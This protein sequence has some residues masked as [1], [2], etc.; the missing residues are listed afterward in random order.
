MIN[1]ENNNK[2]ILVLKGATIIPHTVTPL[3]LGRPSS[4]QSLESALEKKEGIGVFLQKN[5]DSEIIDINDIYPYGVYVKIID[6]AKNTKGNIKVLL[7][8]INRIQIKSI[9][10]ENNLLHAEYTPVETTF[11]LTEEIEWEVLWK[12][13]ISF[14]QKYK[15]YNKKLPEAFIPHS[16]SLPDI[17]IAIDIVAGIILLNW[18]DCLILRRRVYQ[19]DRLEP[20]VC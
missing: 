18:F 9:L 3:L 14:Y 16:F 2:A 17:E 5:S 20:R 12:N 19:Q 8:G 1:I 11:T 7:E 10:K 15:E 6:I 4:I 13:F